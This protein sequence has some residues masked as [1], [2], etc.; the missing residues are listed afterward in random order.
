MK[1]FLEVVGA[2]CLAFVNGKK[3]ALE[4]NETPQQ[5]LRKTKETSKQVQTFQPIL[6]T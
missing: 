3:V 4:L 6:H 1:K 2:V 5:T